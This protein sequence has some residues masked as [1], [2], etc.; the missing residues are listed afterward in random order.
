MTLDYIPDI[1]LDT[2]H[3]F[4]AAHRNTTEF[5]RMYWSI[6]QRLAPNGSTNPGV[7]FSYIES[8]A[9]SSQDPAQVRMVATGLLYLINAQLEADDLKKKSQ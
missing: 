2:F 6:R 7:L 5:E 8:V 9:N 4:E 3:A 1:S